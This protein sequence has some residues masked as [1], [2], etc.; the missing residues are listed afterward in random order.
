[1]TEGLNELFAFLHTVNLSS[2]V[3][4]GR[5][6]PKKHDNADET[7]KGGSKIH[8]FDRKMNNGSALYHCHCWPDNYMK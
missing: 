5:T 2:V 7:L 3:E 1:M 8:W 4:I 6:E